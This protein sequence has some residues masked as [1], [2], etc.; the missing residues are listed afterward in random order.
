MHVIKA[1][2]HN[3]G[4]GAG[5]LSVDVPA[6]AAVEYHAE[7]GK[8]YVR[9]ADVEPF[10]RHD[11]EYRGIPVELGNVYVTRAEYMGGFPRGDRGAAKM[12]FRAYYAQFITDT[13]RHNVRAHIGLPRLL[14]STN[15]DDAFNDIPLRQWDMLPGLPS[16]IHESFKERGDWVSPAGTV[17]LYKEAARQLVDENRHRFYC[18]GRTDY[19][20]I[21]DLASDPEQLGA[22]VTAEEHDEM[23]GC[24][25][26]IY[27]KGVPGFL[28]GEPITGDERG[29][30]YA[31]YYISADG[32]YCARYHCVE[33]EQ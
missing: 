6:G 26:P 22:I 17:A 30:V 15:E 21:R 24:V 19:A 25:P 7:N 27:A 11:A 16:H 33:D 9:A 12:A 2:S 28:V 23:L 32:L 18:R 29:T 8:F 3:F 20:A 5:N 14:A 4:A 1:F 10:A 13:V 31:H